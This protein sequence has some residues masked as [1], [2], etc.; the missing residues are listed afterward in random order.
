M[1]THHCVEGQCEMGGLMARNRQ[2]EAANKKLR[3]ALKEVV[4]D[5]LSYQRVNNLA[6]SPGHK[7]CWRSVGRALGVL[8]Q[9]TTEG[10]E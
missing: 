6:P 7:Y 8:N 10:G 2:L 5:V 3:T 4:G 9:Q 1:T